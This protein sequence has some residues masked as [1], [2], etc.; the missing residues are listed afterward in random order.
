[1]AEMGKRVATRRFTIPVG[2]WVLDDERPPSQWSSP[3]H[4]EGFFTCDDVGR[5]K[6]DRKA[7]G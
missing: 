4:W 2:L 5:R 6:K 3:P 7:R 1:M